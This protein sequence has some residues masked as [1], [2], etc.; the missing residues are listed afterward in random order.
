MTVEVRPMEERDRDRVVALHA[1]AFQ[2]PEYRLA[3]QRNMALDKGWVITRHGDVVGGLRVDLVGQFFGG[4]S[5]PCA[6]ITAVK[7]APE[8]RGAGLGRALMTEVVRALSAKG[9]TL[10]TLYPSGP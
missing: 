1:Q 6:V 8:A 3:R 7:L 5:V 4:R 2:V 10:S 9:V